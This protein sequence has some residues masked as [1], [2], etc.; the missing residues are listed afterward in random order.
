MPGVDGLKRAARKAR[1]SPAPTTPD[2]IEIA[3]EAE[4][5]GRTPSGPAHE[6]LVSQNQLV[7]WEIADRQA[8]L[9]LKLLTSAVGLA[10]A[11]SLAAMAWSAS[12]SGGLVVEPF[13]V[14][15]DLAQRGLTGQAVA[16]QLLDKLLAMQDQTMSAKPARRYENTGAEIKVEIPQTGISIGE[17][18]RYL[19]QWLGHET[20]VTGEIFRT[21][22]GL[23]V[24][25]RAGD[26]A[27]DAV[28]GP[29]TDLD[30]LVQATAESIYGRAEPYRYAR[31]LRGQGRLDEANARLMALAD[32]SDGQDRAWAT[33]DVMQIL[34]GRG[35]FRGAWIRAE[36]AVQ[37]APDNPIVIARYKSLAYWS[38]RDEAWRTAALRGIEL[39]RRHP[40]IQTEQSRHIQEKIFEAD[41][42]ETQGDF[43]AAARHEAEAAALGDY[44]F[45]G[46]EAATWVGLDLALAHDGAGADAAF[47]RAEAARAGQ[48]RLPFLLHQQRLPAELA[49]GR[50][51]EALQAGRTLEAIANQP[52]DYRD[53]RIEGLNK[54]IFRHAATAQLGYAMAMTGD[55]LGGETLAASTPLDCYRCIR[56]RGQIAALK[57]DRR[58]AA[59]WFGEA[60]RIGPSLPFAATEWGQMLLSAGDPSGA[61]GKFKAANKLGPKFADPLEGWGEALMV[62]GDA[63]GAAKKFE[64]ASRF[65]PR[66]GRLHLK[67]GEALAKLGKA[68]EARAKWRAAATMDLSAA[69]RA[70]LKAHGV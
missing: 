23:K 26:L 68:D 25:A 2:P 49:L 54:Q 58:T 37:M 69:D 66:W 40:E 24:T 7:R 12:R 32:A 52:F 59:H 28:S 18:N 45:N 67:W 13:S 53:E 43:M 64:A 33:V 31:Y 65:A 35:D 15:P 39:L 8:G 63:S 21:A 34:F 29:D 11:L 41:L 48:P 70:V 60:E 27:G 61:I 16:V 19:R 47:A 36:A 6:L 4:A 17:L 62:K 30:R 55:G 14:P 57:G 5:S 51:S 10:A 9:A 22:T 3:M 44:E 42:G 38:G 50:W 56:I 1:P 46:P 20:H